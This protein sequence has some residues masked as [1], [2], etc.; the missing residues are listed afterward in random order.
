MG[1]GGWINLARDQE[2]GS[3]IASVNDLSGE[4]WKQ[5]LKDAVA[6]HIQ[7]M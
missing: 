6:P 5:A 7:R 4:V 1:N 2:S 3:G